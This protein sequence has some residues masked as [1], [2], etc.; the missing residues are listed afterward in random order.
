MEAQ[1][2]SV[3]EPHRHD[4]NEYYEWAPRIL[5]LSNDELLMFRGVA[6][7][8]PKVLETSSIGRGHVSN[9]TQVWLQRSDD[10]GESWDTPRILL[11]HPKYAVSSLPLVD[12]KTGRLVC[13]YTLRDMVAYIETRDPGAYL[14]GHYFITS[15]DDGTSWSDPTEVTAK[16][17]DQIGLPHGEHVSTS[18][19]L[20]VTWYGADR[21]EALFS[22]DNGQSWG[23]RTEI[24]TTI[25]VDGRQLT[26][27]CAWSFTDD[28][29][30][31][32]GRDNE[33][34]DFFAVKSS[35]GGRSWGSPVYFN[36]TDMNTGVPICVK[37]TGANEITATWGDRTNGYVYVTHMS[38]RLAWQDPTELAN[39]QHH[40]VHKMMADEDHLA[41]FGYSHFVQLGE[42]RREIL[43]SFYDENETPN[44]WLMGAY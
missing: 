15:D 43:L 17:G 6:K 19:G 27:P 37:Q 23:D 21:I 31:T 35:D 25:E 36:P 5:R 26:E 41:D 7:P 13:F 30:V 4:Q 20:M 2:L 18:N 22:T 39:Q 29:I 3:L 24:G 42:S 40:R 1:R 38:A 12:P 11:D 32:F 34:G 14:K 44:P 28:R 8:D 16:L 9:H 10:L 33:T